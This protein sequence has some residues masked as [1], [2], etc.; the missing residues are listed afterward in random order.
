MT[1]EILQGKEKENVAY[2]N[3]RLPNCMDYRR[4]GRLLS[5]LSC[6]S[7]RT[8]AFYRR[9]L[10]AIRTSFAVYHAQVVT[11]NLVKPRLR[12]QEQCLDHVVNGSENHFPSSMHTRNVTLS[13]C[14]AVPV[15]YTFV[16]RH[17]NCRCGSGSSTYGAGPP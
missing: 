1:E 16:G 4:K 5:S 7:L 15:I 11:E 14:G 6:Y 3:R 2:P 17:D 13:T 8:I 10:T 9:S 12:E